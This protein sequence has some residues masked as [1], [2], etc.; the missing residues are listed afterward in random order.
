MQAS[1]RQ[2]KVG[3]WLEVSAPDG[4]PARRGVIVE[5]LGRPDHEHY[6]VYWT[7]DSESI[8]YPSDGTSI[9]PAAAPDPR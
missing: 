6:I 9:V 2:G 4:G 7:D 1:T 5:I 8:H 3:D